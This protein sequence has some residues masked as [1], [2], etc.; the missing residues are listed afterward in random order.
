MYLLQRKGKKNKNGKAQFNG[1]FNEAVIN[2]KG[3]NCLRTI[4]K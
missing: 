1:D 3:K 2:Y 4:E